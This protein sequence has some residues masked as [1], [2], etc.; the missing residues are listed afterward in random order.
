MEMRS[1]FKREFLRVI[2]FN[3]TLFDIYQNR[4]LIY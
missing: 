1:S 4:L 3:L 2:N